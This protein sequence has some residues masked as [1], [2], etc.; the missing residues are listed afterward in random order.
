MAYGLIATPGAVDSH[1]HLISPELMPAA[2][3][4]GV[5]T[6]V[7][8]GF[9]EPPWAMERTL[10]ALDRLAAERRVPGVCPLD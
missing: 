9:E 4:G 6:L 1:V 8:A 10:A 5:T 3:S 7:T 2:L